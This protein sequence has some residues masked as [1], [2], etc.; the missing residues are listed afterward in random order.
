MLGN[1]G[2]DVKGSDIE[3]IA[4]G[5]VILKIVI[6]GL[7]EGHVVICESSSV[8]HYKLCVDGM[9]HTRKSPLDDRVSHQ[10]KFLAAKNGQK[11]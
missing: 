4:E 2:E 9:F 11:Q 1:A 7:E 8:H 3:V 5:S 6:P 10:Q